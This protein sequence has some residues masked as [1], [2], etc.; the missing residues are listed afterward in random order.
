MFCPKCGSQRPDTDLFCAQCGQSL[1]GPVQRSRTEV[2]LEL[3]IAQQKYQALKE[4]ADR[5]SRAVT[6]E[7]MEQRRELDRMIHRLVEE[8]IAKGGPDQSDAETI[9]Q[10]DRSRSRIW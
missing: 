7:K 8:G 6:K 2:L 4:E 5:Y 1:R 3:S 10:L 9:T